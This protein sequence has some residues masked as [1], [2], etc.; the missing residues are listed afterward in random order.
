MNLTPA[1]CAEQNK[2]LTRE[3]KEQESQVQDLILGNVA[4]EQEESQRDDMTC[5]RGDGTF[6][7]SG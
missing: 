5:S 7:N 3:D 4:K 1:T 2:H 6:K